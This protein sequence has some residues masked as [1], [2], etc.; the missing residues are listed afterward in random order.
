MCASQPVQIVYMLSHIE[1][2][3]RAITFPQLYRLGPKRTE[4]PPA[5]QTLLNLIAVNH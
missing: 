1:S 4:L 3:C 2:E 5:C